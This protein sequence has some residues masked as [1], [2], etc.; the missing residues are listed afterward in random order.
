VNSGISHLPVNSEA[1]GA[2]FG[3]S[4]GQSAEDL[5]DHSKIAP[6]AE[7]RD[8]DAAELTA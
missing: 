5:E 1:G 3:F 8:L 6:G 4:A 2:W 7:V